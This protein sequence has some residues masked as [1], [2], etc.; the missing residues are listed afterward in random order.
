VQRPRHSDDFGRGVVFSGEMRVLLVMALTLL[1]TGAASAASARRT[2]VPPL[3]VGE[4][5]ELNGFIALGGSNDGQRL[6]FLPNRKF[7]AGLVLKASRRLRL[8]SRGSRFSSRSGRSSSRRA[9]GS[10]R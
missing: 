4:V 5:S 6:R 3:S 7:A 10:T 1:L 9:H 2:T 8:S